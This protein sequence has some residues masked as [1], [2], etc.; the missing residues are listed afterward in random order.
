MM[1]SQHWFS[2]SSN[3]LVLLPS[4]QCWPRCLSSYCTASLQWVNRVKHMYNYHIST[5]YV[6]N[7]SIKG[8]IH[9]LFVL[10]II[11]S[12]KLFHHMLLKSAPRE[13]KQLHT[14]VFNII[15]Y[16]IIRDFTTLTQWNVNPTD[17][18]DTKIRIHDDVI[19]WNGFRVTGP[20]WGEW[21]SHQWI[22]LT[23]ASNASF[24]VFFAASLNK[25]SSCRWCGMPG[26]SLWHYRNVI[27]ALDCIID[28]DDMVMQEA[29]VWEGIILAQFV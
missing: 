17:I 1:I 27:V 6:I 10:N 24:N 9:V 15:K 28:A 22:P 13:V 8:N 2:R 3:G 16:T 12:W 19:K 18:L 5:T 4:S 29:R 26:H 20:L 25:Q 14:C 7:V 11:N 23:K 21:T